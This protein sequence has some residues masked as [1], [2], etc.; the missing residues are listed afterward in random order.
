[1]ASLLVVGVPGDLL[2]HLPVEPM[3]LNAAAQRKTLLEIPYM[4]V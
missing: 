1:M 3:F 2:H 4:N